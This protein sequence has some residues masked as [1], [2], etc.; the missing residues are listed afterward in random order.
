M[1][2]RSLGSNKLTLKFVVIS[3]INFVVGYVIFSLAWLSLKNYLSY[4]PIATFATIL[5]AVWSFQSHN[6]VTLQ[7]KSIKSFVSIQYLLF[8]LIGLLIGTLCVPEIADSLNT[9]LLFVQLFWTLFLS[10]IGLVILVK[11]SEEGIK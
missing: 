8:Q 1:E 11:Y 7:R 5:S 9:N 2:K 3:G 10:L 4:L 6:R